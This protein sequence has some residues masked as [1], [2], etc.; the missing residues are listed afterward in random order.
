MFFNQLLYKRHGFAVFCNIERHV[1]QS[2][3]W[4]TYKGDHADADVLFVH[5]GKHQFH[6][7][8]A[9]DGLP[10]HVNIDLDP[11]QGDVLVAPEP[12]SPSQL[13]LVAAWLARSFVHQGVLA[14]TSTSGPSAST[15]DPLASTSATGDLSNSS[16]L[17]GFVI[18]M[19]C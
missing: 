3:W 16:L 18:F 4:K 9:I 15:S 11:G 5:V 19:K 6:E 10:H 2:G 17:F 8:T 14:A 12:T 1:F 13:A 7:L